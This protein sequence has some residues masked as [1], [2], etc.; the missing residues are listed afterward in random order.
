MSKK[1]QIIYADPPWDYTLIGKNFGSNITKLSDGSFR[2]VVSARDHYATMTPMEISS[3]NIKDFVDTNC[4]LFLWVTSPLL[5][6][7]VEILALWGFTYK[8]IAFVWHKE[9]LMPGAYTMSSCE[10]CLVGKRGNIPKPRG[11]RN[12]KQFIQ[13]KRTNHSQKP[14]EARQRIEAMFPSQNKLELFARQKVE[15]WDC[16]GNEVNSDIEL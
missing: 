1:Y 9:A 6:K 3:L 13:V 11:V 16:W 7:G 4:L 2:A 15:G 5:D 8:T 14:E 10:V 12:A